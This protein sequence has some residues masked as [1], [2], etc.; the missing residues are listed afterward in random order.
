MA[1]IKNGTQVSDQWITADDDTPVQADIPTIVSYKR[2]LEERETLVRSR[3]E[4]G[5]KV[6]PGEDVTALERDLPRLQVIALDFP[7]FT[8][9]RSYSAAR[10]LRQRLGFEGEIRATGEV[11]RD[12]YL[13]M[14]R[15]GFDS[16]EVRDGVEARQ[17]L[18]AVREFSHYY[19]PAP[20]GTSAVWALRH[21]G[22]AAA[23]E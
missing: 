13:F 9:G 22:L 19:Q 16:F 21:A 18:D 4:L 15:A 5:V 7:K 3:A 8:D 10:I 2:F 23:A 6:A 20:N 12:Q 17:W 11:L 1:L 14:Q